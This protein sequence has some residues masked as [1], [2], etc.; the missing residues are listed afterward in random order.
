MRNDW[1]SGQ[2]D[3]I[4]S[5][6][7]ASAGHSPSRMRVLWTM[8]EI[9]ARRVCQDPRAA[10][11]E[12]SR[13]GLHWTADLRPDERGLYWKFIT[14]D[15][16]FA[17]VLADVEATVLASAACPVFPASLGTQLPATLEETLF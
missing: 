4:V 16:R 8:T 6:F 9:D 7:L 13:W 1:P 12:H 3:R 14:D 5:V 17:G 15:G 10:D 2:P 11:P